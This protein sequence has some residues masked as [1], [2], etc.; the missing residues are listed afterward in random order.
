MDLN[1]IQAFV[2]IVEA[3]NLAEAG[4]RRGVTRSQ[5]SRQ[6]GQ[7]EDQAG[8]QLLRR[9][10]RRLE[11]TDSGQSLYEHGLRILQEVAAAQAEID[12]LGKTLRGHVRVSVPTGLGDAF[13]APLLLQFAERHPGIS[14]RVFFAN[15]VTDLIAAE[16]DVALRVTSEPPLDTVAREVCAI[17]WQLCAS[18]GYLAQVPPVR[19][20]ADLAACRFLCP[21]YTTRRFSLTLGRD[22]A[23]GPERRNVEVTPYLQSE[24][25]PFLIRAVREGHGI[26]LLPV[27]AGWEDVRRGSLVPVLPDWKPEGL[28]NRLYIITTPNPHPSMATR[29]LISFLRE[30]VA[31]LD[32]FSTS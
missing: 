19:E 6:L 20:P 13:I 17:R 27:Y 18:P 1:L 28:G 22:T 9:T 12:S 30:A 29:A 11:M 16:I 3:G 7:L 2:D 24:H 31:G 21:P 26:S 25:F 4:R 32:V 5:I 10:T 8:T 23:H 14:L 15:R